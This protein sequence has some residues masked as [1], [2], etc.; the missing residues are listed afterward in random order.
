MRAD[1]PRDLQRLK[2]SLD[3]LIRNEARARNTHATKIRHQFAFALLYKRLFSAGQSDWIL[4]GG[5][6]L[7]IRTGGGRFTQDIDLALAGSE[8]AIEDL[9]AELEHYLSLP[10]PGDPF[11]F[12]LNKLFE[13]R[14]ADAFGYGTTT[15]KATIDILLG[16]LPFHTIQADI[17][18]QRHIYGP[19]DRVR[20]SPIIEHELIS[21]LPLV[22]TVPIENH[23]ADKVCAMYEC[24]GAAKLPSTRYRDLADIVRIV[25]MLPLD[26]ARLSQMLKHESSRRGICLPKQMVSPGPLWTTEFKRNAATFEE[27]PPELRELVAALDV[28]GACLNPILDGSVSIGAWN[29]GAFHWRQ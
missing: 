27:Y 1:S 10:I 18:E 12:R 19:V 7:L 16:A 3:S 17:T 20:I 24:H 13:T 21:D 8:R 6:A 2:A 9:R 25:T 11:V 29:L 22:P 5:N 26:G 23:L 14:R 28:A 15:I 4:L